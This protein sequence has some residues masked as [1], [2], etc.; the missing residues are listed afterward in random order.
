MPKWSESII[1]IKAEIMSNINNPWRSS[2][3]SVA[4]LD[5]N[6][7]GVM[8]LFKSKQVERDESYKILLG[9]ILSVVRWEG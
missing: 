8:I 7:W 6:F 5:G 3:S 1:T 4:T 9:Q 2:N